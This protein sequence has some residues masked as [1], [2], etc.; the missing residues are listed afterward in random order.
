LLHSDLLTV[1]IAS[2]DGRGDNVTII[3]KVWGATALAACMVFAFAADA[4]QKA[5]EKVEPA[6]KTEKKVKAKSV[7]NAITEEAAC[8]A[9]ATCAWVAALK[10]AKT[11]KQKRKAYCRTKPK[12]PAKK[13]KDKDKEKEPAKK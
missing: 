6:A 1:Y 12:P 11:G 2:F 10:D 9:N 7:C 8:K 4:Q 5:P 3:G 13:A